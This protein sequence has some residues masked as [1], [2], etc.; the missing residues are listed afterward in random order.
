MYTKKLLSDITQELTTLQSAGKYKTERL[1]A[2]AQGPEVTIGDKQVLMF[3]SNNYLGLCNHPEIVAAAKRGLDQYGYGLSSVRFICGTQEL[4]RQLE[5]RIAKFLGADDAIL[6]STCFMA[7]LGFFASI[8]NESFGAE[9]WQDAI[10]SDEL[11]HASMIDAF[12][13]IKKGTVEKRVYPHNDIAALEVMLEADKDKG[14][15]NKF[16]V[17]DGVFSMEGYTAKLPEL[18]ALARQYE[19]VL[20]VDDAHAVGVLGATGAG[21]PEFLGIHGQIDVLSGTLGKALGGAVGG[22]IAA[23]QEI[24]D[25]LRQKS[26]TYM[27]SNSI[28]PSVVVASLAA[29]DL[30]ERNPELLEKSRTNTTYFREKVKA[31]GFTIL[32]GNHPVAPV[33][34]GEAHV[35][36]QMSKKLLEHGLY[37]VGLWFPVVPEGE[38]RLR[39]Q[40]SAAHTIEQ[41]DRAVEI[42]GRV[43]KEMGVIS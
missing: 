37:V 25:L 6:Y 22:Y 1:L 34:L 20:F 11:N 14:F 29:F 16:I 38:A 27:F 28:P 7:N 8:T 24:I 40:V 15:R 33:M 35:A 4:H 5:Q 21:T 36:Q 30:L 17:T 23:K 43:G 19:A 26:R 41:I 13:L 9:V 10:Y 39:F 2:S 42:L 31:L 12:K 3:A 18:V 32:D